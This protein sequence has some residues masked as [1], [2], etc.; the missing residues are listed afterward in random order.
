MI[1]RSTWTEEGEDYVNFCKEAGVKTKI[2]AG[3]H[4]IAAAATERILLPEMSQLKGLRHKWCW[5]KR[6]RL[7]VPT[8]SFAKVP[9]VTFFKEENFRM[10][11]VYMRPWSLN[12]ADASECNPL[13]NVLG[14]C[15]E[16]SK[17]GR[18]SWDFEAATHHVFES[19][20]SHTKRKKHKG[21]NQAVDTTAKADCKYV[22]SYATSWNTYV[23]GNVV[24]QTS[25]R[26]IQNMLMATAAVRTEQEDDSS[27]DSDAEQ[28]A[29]LDM[30]VG[31]MDTVRSTL[32][33]IARHSVDDGQSGFG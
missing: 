28:W 29:H 5:E 9:R 1:K 7:H 18:R 21:E 12:P 11:S 23:Q 25:K 22:Y 8:W 17:T 27:D 33:G 3:K 30:N 10:M 15:R 31:D 14:L 16:D 4:Y 20:E 6:H 24:S 19:Q 26:L 32:R 13:L 2:I